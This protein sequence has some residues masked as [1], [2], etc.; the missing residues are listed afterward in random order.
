MDFIKKHYR[1]LLFSIPVLSLVLHFHVFNLDLVG[2]H[3]WRQTETQTV[4]NNFYRDDLNIFNPRMN[5]PA[6]TDRLHR[7]EF[8]LMQ[9][10]FALFY[11]I[12][13]P[14]IV[15]SRVISFLIG[16]CSVYGMFYLCD[17]VFK[18]KATATISAWCF[19][20]SPV[21]YYYTV[22]P[23][24]DNM[25][26]CCG[27]WSLGLFYNYT[28]THNIK[29]VIGS[30]LLLALATLVK[31]P[32]ILY[33]AFAFTFLL[34]QLKR[35]EYS[36]KQLLQIVVIYLLFIIPALC[37][38]AAVIPTWQNGVTKG[39]LETRQ[40]TLELLE[41]LGGTVSSVLPELLLNYGSVLFFVAGCWFLF[42]HKKYRSRYFPLFLVSGS[43]LILYFLF[44]MNMITTVHDYYLFPFLPFLF[45]LVGYGAKC[46]LHSRVRAATLLSCLCLAVLPLTAFL[47]INSRWDLKDPG[48][49]PVYYT[50]RDQIRQLTPANALCISGNDVS[51]HILLYYIDRKGWTYDED[52]LTE[53]QLNYYRSKGAQYLFVNGQIDD[54][55]DIKAHL[56]V[57][58]FDKE[59]LRVYKLK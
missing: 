5:S 11:K 6:D 29:Y 36:I 12:I 16:L 3:V 8:P 19:N 41:I 4:I 53:D 25:A 15:I 2:I 21:F 55:A 30:S 47:R 35:K 46:M 48:F 52:Q 57:K 54:R 45:L 59:T 42:K 14:H 43:A 23:L 31:L 34:L 13:G 40:T 22:N 38:Y 32:F 26:L 24:P 10:L 51:R 44:E 28:I 27:I 49:D 33:G 1:L 58:I 20:F 18:N 50:Y 37:W 7:M 39:L 56:A 9:W 17:K